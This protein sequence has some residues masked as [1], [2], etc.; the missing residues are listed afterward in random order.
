MNILNT[1][2]YEYT[3]KEQI[4]NCSNFN[5]LLNAEYGQHGTHSRKQFEAEVEVF[6]RKIKEAAKD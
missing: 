6:F 1:N 4:V 5:Q 2:Q 3:K